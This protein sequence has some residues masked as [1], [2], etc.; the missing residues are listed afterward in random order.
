MK[1]SVRGTRFG[2][3]VRIQSW[4][5]RHLPRIWSRYWGA[6]LMATTHYAQQL[7]QQ[8][9]DISGWMNVKR[10]TLGL[11]IFALPLPLPIKPQLHRTSGDGSVHGDSE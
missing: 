7:S 5:A 2:L 1:T 10:H 8:R 6:R 4:I 11:L 9:P 3:S